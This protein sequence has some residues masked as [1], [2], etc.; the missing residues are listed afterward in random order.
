MSRNLQKTG[1]R[2]INKISTPT[3][4]LVAMAVIVVMAGHYILT[5]AR[6][7]MITGLV[8]S[9]ERPS[10]IINRQIVHEGTVV[11]GVKV[12]KIY[13]DRVEFEKNWKR[14]TQEVDERPSLAWPTITLN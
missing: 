8:Y 11:Y 4:L 12:I 14:W 9:M 3:L 10:A 13:T 7:G 1:G 6:P 2:I 5:A